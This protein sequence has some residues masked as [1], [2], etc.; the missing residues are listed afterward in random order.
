MSV[1]ALPIVSG[2]IYLADLSQEVKKLEGDCPPDER[3]FV[4]VR[5]A[6]EADTQ[7]ISD[8]YATRTT[9]WKEDAVEEQ[10][11]INPRLEW[12]WQAFMTLCDAGNILDAQG[13]P[14]FKFEDTGPYHKVS[15]GFNDF[16]KAHGSLNSAVT[17][18]IRYAVWGINPQWDMRV[19]VDESGEP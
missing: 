1:K 6:T 19:K 8:L 13:K 2:S 16:R 18:A 14:L 11:D 4:V 5:Q 10:R 7:R 9:R 12:V 17:E 15:G 3:A